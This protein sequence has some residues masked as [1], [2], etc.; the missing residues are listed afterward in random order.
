MRVES[1]ALG[2]LDVED[3]KLI[4]FPL[5]IPGFERCKHFLLAEMGAGEHAV[6]LFQGVDDPDA[7]FSVTTPEAVGLH[8]EFELTAEEMALLGVENASDV[9]VM[10]ILR[11]DSSGDGGGAVQ[12]NLMAPL[13]I[14]ASTRRGIQKVIARLG[15]EVTLKPV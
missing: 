14:N 7:S 13:V 11:R 1:P 4:E 5:G 2:S 9:A 6:A 12:A 8:Y 15:C 3:S 10:L